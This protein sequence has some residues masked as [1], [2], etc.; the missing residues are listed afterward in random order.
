MK[1]KMIDDVIYVEIKV[2][3]EFRLSKEKKSWLVATSRGP[4]KTKVEIDG[5]PVFMIFNAYVKR[6]KKKKTVI[7]KQQEAN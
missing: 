1:A 2:L 4:V 7:E 5:R 6:L 3:E